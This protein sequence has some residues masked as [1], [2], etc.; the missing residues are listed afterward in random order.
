MT[1]GVT[2]ASMDVQRDEALAV[3]WAVLSAE[4][5]AAAKA[6]AKAE[7]SAAS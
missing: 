6:V 1:A 2:A 4:L 7:L 5:K 3:G